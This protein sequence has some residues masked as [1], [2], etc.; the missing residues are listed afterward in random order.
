MRGEASGTASE[1]RPALSDDQIAT[2]IF[3]HRK[4]LLA[5]IHRT[6]GNPVWAEDALSTATLR[7]FKQ[8]REQPLR[9]EGGAPLW[10]WLTRANLNVGN[11]ETRRCRGLDVARKAP[12]GEEPAQ[13]HEEYLFQALLIHPE[14]AMAV[15][16]IAKLLDSLSAPDRQFVAEL[17]SDEQVGPAS[18][19][20][21]SRLKRLRRR[22]RPLFERAGFRLPNLRNSV[23]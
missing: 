2:A 7:L 9:F 4:R 8:H 1:L 23:Q 22:L 20:H 21:R 19:A 14:E 6:F 16:D 10:C 5:R 3:L 15:R 13:T 11:E 17:L 18:D 12:I